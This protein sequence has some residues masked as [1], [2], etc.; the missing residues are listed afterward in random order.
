MASMAFGSS[1]WLRIDCLVMCDDVP[2]TLACGG[3]QL[4]ETTRFT[5]KEAFVVGTF[6][7]LCNIGFRQDIK[8]WRITTD[9]DKNKMACRKGYMQL[10]FRRDKGLHIFEPRDGGAGSSNGSFI[11][12]LRTYAF[13]NIAIGHLLSEL[14]ICIYS[15][16]CFLAC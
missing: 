8:K 16:L 4:R 13:S 12:A 11:F 2:L 14:C 5:S 7:M 9:K 1:K 10:H 15:D 3:S 6:E